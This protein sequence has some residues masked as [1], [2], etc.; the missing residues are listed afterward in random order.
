MQSWF[1]TL[2][3]PPSFFTAS[4]IPF[5]LTSPTLGN[6]ATNGEKLTETTFAKAIEEE[7]N[8]G[9]GAGGADGQ[10]LFSAAAWCPSLLP[11]LILFS[12]VI[13]ENRRREI[14]MTK[15]VAC[16]NTISNLLLLVQ[17]P[18]LPLPW[19]CVTDF[20]KSRSIS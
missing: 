16:I 10:L 7:Q 5:E 2:F 8:A 11:P 9:A 15:N 17:I 3:P 18:T 13:S 6:H 12:M 20:N 19:W 4:K 14:V 1:F